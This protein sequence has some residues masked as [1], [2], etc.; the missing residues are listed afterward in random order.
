M[1]INPKYV[2]ILKWKKGEQG[3][4]KE[5]QKSIKDAI[6]P[7]IEI[8]P[9]FNEDK[10]ESSLKIWENRIFYFDVIPECYETDEQIYFRLL[11]KLDPN[12]VI[13]VVCIDDDLESID[14]ANSLSNLGIALRITTN[15]I[16]EIDEYL[17]DIIKKIKP[18]NIDLIIDISSINDD[19]SK[20][21]FTLFKA[22]ISSIPTPKDF[23][24][25]ILSGSSF[26]ESLKSVGKY[27]YGI[28]ARLELDFWKKCTKKLSTKYDTNF[29]YSDY[30]INNPKYVDFVPGMSP[31]FNIRYTSE[32]YFIVFKGD[33]VKKGGLDSE[34]VQSLCNKLLSLDE[35]M[36]PDFSCGDNYIYTRAT[37]DE[38]ESYGNLS[39]WRKVGTNHH[40]TF[41]IN[42][43]SNLL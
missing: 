36:G 33:M 28:F 27:D 35:F 20:E 40:I 12:F 38:V 34:N 7:L 5:L 14:S 2:P 41:V 15:E 37:D 6:I 26:P 19:N 42:Q 4:L 24:N 11:K 29:V 18:S 39:T 3:A 32:D 30:C 25:I 9:D 8:T 10:L 21:K 31:Y 22:L 23:R 16:D 17:D 1:N 13:P 43:L